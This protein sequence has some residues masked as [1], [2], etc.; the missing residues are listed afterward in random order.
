VPI[1]HVGGGR[2]T[3]VVYLVYLLYDN[4]M[5]DCRV[6]ICKLVQYFSSIDFVDP[7]HFLF[8]SYN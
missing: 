3:P 2:S 1:C 6:E 4:H 7:N 5:L 8:H